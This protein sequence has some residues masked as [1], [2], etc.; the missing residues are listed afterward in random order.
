[1]VYAQSRIVLENETHKIHWDFAIQVEYLIP[2]GRPDLV[3]ILK[4]SEPA[5]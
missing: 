5:E 4:K 3:I 1:M 2:A